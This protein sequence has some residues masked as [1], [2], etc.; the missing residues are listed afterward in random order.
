MTRL[1]LLLAFVATPTWA[2]PIEGLWQT[3]PDP[4]GRIGI[5]RIAP[6]ESGFCG[7]IVEAKE[8]SGRRLDSSDVGRTVIWDTAPAG[9]GLYEGRV[10]SP[11]RQRS[12]ESR[13]TLS[14]DR[15]LVEGCMLGQC[16]GGEPWVRVD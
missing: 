6:C 3:A 8:T 13:L 11:G 2:D 10:Y 1:A 12:Y 4:Q 9:P 14:G 15:L 5:V 7:V 16:R